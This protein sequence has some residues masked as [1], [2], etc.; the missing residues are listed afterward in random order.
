MPFA[1]IE[2]LVLFAAKAAAPAAG[3]QPA[4]NPI[5]D[6]LPLFAVAALGYILLLRPQRSEEKRRREELSKI[7]KNDYVVTGAGIFGT[8][9]SVNDETKR[10]V[11]RV[12]DDKNVRLT[13]SKESVAR[14]IQPTADKDKENKEKEKAV[15]TA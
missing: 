5:I 8:V 12:D 3:A 4:K 11:L 10:I 2:T 7:K 1:F 15:E 14:I 13:I 6:L 9:V